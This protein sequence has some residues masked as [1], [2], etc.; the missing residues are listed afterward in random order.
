MTTTSFSTALS[1]FVAATQARLDAD[2][3]RAYPG[4]VA[5]RLS[6]DPSGRKYLRV[7]KA[8]EYGGRSVFCFVRASDGAI[9]KA[10]GWKAPA[11][12]ARGSIYVNA[13]QDAVTTYGA[14][15]L[16]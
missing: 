16:R 14:R 6:V 3:A 8:H 13:G 10:E 12:H 4:A 9:L 5:P 2:Y 11:K 15:Y 1:E 7:V